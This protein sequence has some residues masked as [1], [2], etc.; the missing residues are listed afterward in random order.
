MQAGRER[1]LWARATVAV[2]LIDVFRNVTALRKLLG[3]TP[4]WI[5]CSDRWSASDHVELLERQA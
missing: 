4:N 5:L 3:P 1:W 2:F